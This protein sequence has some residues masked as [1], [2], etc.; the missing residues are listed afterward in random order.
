MNK[1]AIGHNPLKR[2]SNTC[3]KPVKSQI[4]KFENEDAST[5][6]RRT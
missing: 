6:H 2:K 4:L 3:L 5:L 1:Q